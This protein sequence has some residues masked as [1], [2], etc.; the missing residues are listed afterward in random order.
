MTGVQTCALPICE[1]LFQQLVARMYEHGK[2]LS[3]ATFFEIDDVIDP[4]DTRSVITRIAGPE[5]RKSNEMIGAER[6][7][8]RLHY[9]KNY[10]MERVKTIPGVRIGTSL[11]RKYGC[12]IGLVSVEGKKPGALDSFL[13]DKY[14][15]HAVGI[16]WEN[17]IGLRVTPNV[18]TL[19]RDLDVLVEGIDRFAKT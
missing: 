3:T 12:G 9:L 18:Y 17:I 6:K 19:T 16:E 1:A 5:Q 15:V 10:W 8:Q 11:H 13:L 7:E 4:V 2:A 14:K